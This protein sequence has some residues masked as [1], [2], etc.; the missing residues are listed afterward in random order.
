MKSLLAGISTALQL[1]YVLTLLNAI[2]FVI[3]GLETQLLY[4]SGD[5]KMLAGALSGVLVTLLVAAII[6]VLGVLIAR[7]ILRQN[8]DAPQWFLR[9]TTVLAWAWLVF[10]P[11][12]TVIGLLMLRWRKAEPIGEQSV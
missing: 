11:V 8:N 10:I 6:G 3:W 4:E 5:P 2:G 12:G 1:V 7:P 9:V